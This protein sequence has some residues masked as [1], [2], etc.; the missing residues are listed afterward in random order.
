MTRQVENRSIPF[1]KIYSFYMLGTFRMEENVGENIVICELC[2]S[3]VIS[4]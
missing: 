1:P 4:S 3:H 2:H